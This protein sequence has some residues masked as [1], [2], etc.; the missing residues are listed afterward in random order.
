MDSKVRHSRRTFLQIATSSL[1][2]LH[3]VAQGTPAL[4]APLSFPPEVA[5][6]K[7]SPVD[8][9]A[10]FNASPKDFG[11]RERAKELGG[12][13]GEDGLIRMP[14]GVQQFR[15]IPFLLGPKGVANKGWLALSTAPRAWSASQV[16]VNI[17]KNAGYVCLASF[18]DW[19]KN[20][21][22]RP[23]KDVIEKVGQL[24]ANVVFV[25]DNGI[26]KAL[27]I[28]RRFEVN[29]PS[30]LWG[31][32]SFAALCHRENEP[33]KLTDSLNDAMEWGRLQMGVWDHSYAR[34]TL[35]LCALENPDS[36]QTIKS[37]RFEA[38]NDDP[39]LLCGMT[40]FDGRENPFRYER[41]TLYRITVP[42]GNAEE[43]GRW[44]VDVDLGVVARRYVLPEFSPSEWISAEDKGLGQQ[45]QP[46]HGS[47]HFYVEVAASSEATLSLRD[48]QSGRRYDFDLSK[49][50]AAGKQS[51]PSGQARAEVLEREKVWLHGRVVERATGQPV[52]ARLAFRS[53]QGRYIPPY[54]HRTEVNDGWFE[55]YGADVKLMDT[56]FAYVDGTFQVELPVGDVYVEISK[57]FEYNPLRQKLNIKAEQREL[58]LEL[59]RFTDLR[60]QGWVTA[61]THVHFLSPSTA[62]LEGEAEGVNLI[63]LLAAQ[64]GDMFSNIGDM[65]HGPLTSHDRRTLVQ[66]G[67]ENR[68]HIL[69]H[70][71]LLGGQKAANPLSA[72]GPD[73][74]YIGDPL[75]TTMAGWADDCHKNQGL[76]VGAH[77]PYPTGEIAA[78][79]AL[80]KIDALEIWPSGLYQE[81]TSPFDCLR[82]LDW[83]RYLNAGY[84][85]PAV[86]GTDKMGA[87]MPVGTNRAYT[88]LGDEEFSFTNWARAVRKGNTF[89]TSG[90][91]ITFRVDGHLPGEKITLG[92]GGGTV[93]VKTEAEC[94]VPIHRLE[95]VVN[96]KVVATKEQEDGARKL[97]LLEKIRVPGPGWLAARC[98]S[99]LGPVTK[100]HFRV[101]AHTS[102]VYVRVPGQELFSAPAIAYMLKLVE[103]SQVWA[104]NLAT[105]PDFESYQRIRRLFAEAHDA[106]HRRLQ[107]RGHP[108]DH[109]HGHVHR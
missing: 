14:S 25:Y 94:F 12:Q 18:C 45:D 103:G 64:W 65:P 50:E 72:G 31:H 13:S 3:F 11:P 27:P 29:S 100:W 92:S 54:G 34:P 5:S 30:V 17:N 75:W 21:V 4:A 91:L 62:L 57:G 38:A 33:N 88:Y 107:Q 95:I 81:T 20:E 58:Q 35:W 93:E 55:D 48:K 56:S 22:P 28:R 59:E 36:S 68:Q 42:E 47:S 44:E 108:H 26:E 97:S 41:L 43:T 84:R 10:Y 46:V 37:I 7:F 80:G 66:I 102:P 104:E 39:W 49:V 61:D 96:G 40:L 16:D 9:S 23:G 67:T 99:R 1:P 78:D 71:A 74:S 87:Y 76:V 83:Y 53:A 89:V 98:A 8:L 51:A 15:G 85:L 52:A 106:L 19:D 70:L 82:Y 101:S 24:L 2:S 105:R 63:N 60:K 79:V 69:G 32:L 77:F 86:G 6:H 90:P 73:E 109:S